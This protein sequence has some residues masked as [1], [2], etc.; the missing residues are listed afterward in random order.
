MV[1]CIN[2]SIVRHKRTVIWINRNSRWSFLHFG[3]RFFFSRTK[4][5]TFNRNTV[6]GGTALNSDKFF[7]F[8]FWRIYLCL[9][10][11]LSSFTS[12]SWQNFLTVLC[13]TLFCVSKVFVDPGSGTGESC[14]RS[15]YFYAIS[16][17]KSNYTFELLVRPVSVSHLVSTEF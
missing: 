4:G 5:F 17:K 8:I 12:D 14:H 3:S 10:L 6:Y 2:H 15:R 1:V 13:L 11:F 9:Q 16:K 7:R